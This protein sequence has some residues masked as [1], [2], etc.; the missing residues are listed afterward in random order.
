MWI[1]NE[2]L[3][4]PTSEKRLVLM[5]AYTENREL[6]QSHASLQSETLAD[7]CGSAP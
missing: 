2:L 5:N 7:P 6:V 3:S 4:M 1:S